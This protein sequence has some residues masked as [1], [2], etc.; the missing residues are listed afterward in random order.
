MSLVWCALT[1][2]SERWQGR[3]HGRPSE[4]REGG[5]EGRGKEGGGRKGEGGGGKGKGRG[6]ESVDIASTV[7]QK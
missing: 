3:L 4:R 1:T 7:T 6:R 2:G 5:K